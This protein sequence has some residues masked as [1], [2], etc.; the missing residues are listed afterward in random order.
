VALRK[1]RALA[2][3][4]RSLITSG[5]RQSGLDTL[6]LAARSGWDPQIIRAIRNASLAA[7]D[8]ANAWIMTARL[9]ADPSTDVVMRDSLDQSARLALG[10]AGWSRLRDDASQLFSARIL[11]R[12]KMQS[13][14]GT[15]RLRDVRGTTAP[16]A[17]LA[18]G[19]VTVVAFWSRFCGWAL[20]DLDNIGYVAQR[21]SKTGGQL[22]LV[23]DDE[24]EPSP[25]LLSLLASHK[26][27]VLPYVD[28]AHSAS[29]GFNNWGTPQYY[30]LD[31]HGRVRFDV[32]DEARE[33]LVQA[34]ALRLSRTGAVTEG[35]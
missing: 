21:L 18:S 3:L 28:V 33:A 6:K 14:V 35:R 9:V 20:N 15:P 26:V 31:E 27:R 16:L 24:R 19:K 7:G 4:G 22:L 34:E 13:I 12:S 30:V 32:V 2:F 8:S 5:E 25:A 1:G 10:N 11:E 17:K 23:V 29:K